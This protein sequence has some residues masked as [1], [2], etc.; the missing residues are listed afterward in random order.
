MEEIEED[1]GKGGEHS[2]MGESERD[3]NWPLIACAKE[4]YIHDNIYSHI[5]IIQYFCHLHFTSEKTGT[6]RG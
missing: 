3:I 6:L 2:E 5:I 1:A 4:F